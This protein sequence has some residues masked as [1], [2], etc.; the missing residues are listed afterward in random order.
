[1]GFVLVGLVLFLWFCGFAFVFCYLVLNFD[2][3]GN[4]GLWVI[5]YLEKFC[6]FGIAYGG[7]FVDF[8]DRGGLSCL[9]CDF[10]E[11]YDFGF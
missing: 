11:F 8:D 7:I 9:G 2:N 1:M 5:W 6:G 3:F 10:L 4:F